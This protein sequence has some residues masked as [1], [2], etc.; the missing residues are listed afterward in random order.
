MPKKS[1]NKMK[2]PDQ[3]DAA[4][5]LTQTQANVKF[6]KPTSVSVPKQMQFFPDLYRTWAVTDIQTYDTAIYNSATYKA[7]CN[8]N[9]FGPQSNYAGAFAANVPSGSSYLISSNAAS[10]GG[11]PYT[12]V[13]VTDL[14]VEVVVT[15]AFGGGGQPPMYVFIVPSLIGSLAGMTISTIR[16]Q[17]GVSYA[18]VPGTT[19]SGGL[20]EP[21]VIRNKF[22][23]ADIFGR[24]RQEVEQ[25]TLYQHGVGTSPL[26]L[27][28]F[29]VITASFDGSTVCNTVVR[30]RVKSH[31]IFR[32]LNGFTST[33]PT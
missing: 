9:L 19:T 1:N 32:T 18:L 7:N 27:A 2:K 14:E 28:Y 5:Q 21:I 6:S 30:T 11:A 4:G 22:S 26:N 15:N 24:S 12:G 23:I 10:G 33:V 25:N 31:F 8:F 29:H 17:R 3:D 13:T 16:E 20:V